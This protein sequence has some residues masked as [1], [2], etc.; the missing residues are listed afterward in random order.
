MGEHLEQ[1]NER[2]AIY[3]V[4]L[5]LVHSAVCVL[6]LVIR[7]V[8]ERFLLHLDPRFVAAHGYH[9]T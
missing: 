2:D 4:R 1:F 5:E 3:E 9:V 7:P 8:G 6:E